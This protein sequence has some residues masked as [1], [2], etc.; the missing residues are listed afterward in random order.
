MQTEG[1]DELHSKR[2][3]FCYK[4]THHNDSNSKQNERLLTSIK[5]LHCLQCVC[6]FLSFH[7][8][9]FCCCFCCF[10]GGGGGG[11]GGKTGE[12]EVKDCAYVCVCAGEGMG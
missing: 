9:V 1:S 12:G 11:L 7:I 5:S 2:L 10:G 6:V 3:S 8:F 4:K